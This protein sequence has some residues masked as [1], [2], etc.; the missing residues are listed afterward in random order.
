MYQRG[1][2]CSWEG[3]GQARE[4]HK[5][6]D[7]CRTSKNGQELGKAERRDKGI[8]SERRIMNRRKN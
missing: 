7:L 8:L 3:G 4:L 6:E 2:E 1:Q 5:V